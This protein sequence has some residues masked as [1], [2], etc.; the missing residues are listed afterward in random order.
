MGLI[1]RLSDMRRQQII[2]H[3][4]PHLLDEEEVVD[5]ARSRHPH[6]K[7]K[8]FV[9]LTD[10]RFLVVWRGGSEEE[11]DVLDLNQVR[12][13]G[14]EN[15]VGRQPVL[16]VDGGGEPL[17]IELQ[18]ATPAMTEGARQFIRN[19]AALVPDNVGP[20]AD[21]ERFRA[22]P[23]I[24]L[25]PHKRSVADLTKRI[26]VTVLGAA[27][28]IGAILIIPLPGPWSI[29]VTI[30]GLAILAS[31]Y[32]WAEDALDWAKTKYQAAK[33]KIRARRATKQ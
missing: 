13:W 11:S 6:N 17:Y 25:L 5:W 14:L 30:G 19:L 26:I 33:D 28:I 32:D 21:A 12:S 1:R 23:N 15:E 16:C 2:G 3:V 8:G 4:D 27:M 20:P 9:Y 22:D 31:E 7:K 29:L 10:D 24:E 18:T